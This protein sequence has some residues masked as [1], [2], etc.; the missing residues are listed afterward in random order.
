MGLEEILENIDKVTEESV[1]SIIAEANEEA[2]RILGEA[3]SAAKERANASKAK[4]EAD[5]RQLI[6]KEVSKASIASRMAYYA[7]VNRRVGAAFDGITA[8]LQAYAQ[9]P[10]YKKLMAAL[11]ARAVQELGDNCTLLVQ[12]GDDVVVKQGKR[13]VTVSVASERFAGGLKAVSADGKEEIDY[14]LETLVE[15]LRD[16]VATRLLERI[17]GKGN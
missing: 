8:G 10:S 6:A 4:A 17:R 1:R 2:K 14:T 5:S 7:E 16:R 13:K 9:S 11:A 15:R 3:D 12:K